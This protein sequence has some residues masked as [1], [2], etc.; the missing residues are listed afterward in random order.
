MTRSELYP[1]YPVC[2]AIDNT[3]AN[4]MKRL[5]LLG[6]LALGISGCVTPAVS[7]VDSSTTG[8][9]ASKPITGANSEM[10]FLANRDLLAAE[11]K[12]RQTQ[13]ANY[14]YTLQRSCFCTPEFR[15]PI[16]IEVTSGQVQKA[17]LVPEGTL[18]PWERG[19]EALTIEG[20]FD[21]VRKAID[22][23]ASRIDVE[24]DKTYGYPTS[25]SLDP[26]TELADDEMYYTA[27][28][29]K[30]VEKVTL[31]K[32]KKVTKKKSSKK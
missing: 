14:S 26:H 27:T 24:Y 30:A 10:Y 31:S 3:R 12:W 6:M 7:T 19:E 29:L 15:K 23:K 32:A 22:T 25:I 13:P 16:A 20:L 8:S 17:T 11:T 5:L 9:T 1:L 18:L 2:M 21:V 28:E 4:I